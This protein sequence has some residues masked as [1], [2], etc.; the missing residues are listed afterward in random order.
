MLGWL[1]VKIKEAEKMMDEGLIV[2][3]LQTT[4]LYKKD[5][6]VLLFLFNGKWCKSILGAD[7]ML[8][9]NFEV[10]KE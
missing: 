9:D 5:K 2:K 3:N 8:L 10:Y 7:S 1:I 6:G 4:R